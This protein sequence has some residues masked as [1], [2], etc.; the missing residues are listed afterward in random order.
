MTA[1]VHSAVEEAVFAQP[2]VD[3]HCHGV[4]TGELDRA[5]FE[6]LISEGGTPPAGATNFDTPLG[7]AIRRHCAPVLDLEPHVQP[8]RY[9]ARRCELGGAEVTRRLLATTGTAR[10]CV[11]TGFRSGALTTPG[12]LAALAGGR[13]HEIVRLEPLAEAVAARGV[14]PTG[15]EASVTDALHAAVGA[16]GAVGVKS[17]AAYRV[18][19]ELDPER[20]GPD[21]VTA[22][23]ADWLGAGPRGG[24][25]W[26]LDHPVLTR[27]LLWAAVDLGLPIQLHVGFGDADIGM[28]R[29]DPSLLTD[30]LRRHRVPVMLLH[31]W[32]YLRQASFLA[33]V[34]PHVHLDVGLA[35]HHVGPIRA[36]AVLAEAAELAPFGKL[37]YSSDA[38]GVAELYQLGALSFR[39]AL[40]GLLAERVTAGEWSLPDAVR[41]A[42]WIGQHNARRVY[43]LDGGD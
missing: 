5:G 9:L 3:H 22:A 15:F 7:L 13:G 14:D 12:E 27:A 16:S 30:W 17:I 23:A 42:A 2:L 35:L 38:F 31:C 8:E 4:T 18:G 36:A 29:V 41:I 39:R 37:L 1:A 26:R 28:H 10:Y 33:A 20:P 43:R 34:H 11:D 21:Q 6:A 24:G 32:P 40:A 25:E 19:F